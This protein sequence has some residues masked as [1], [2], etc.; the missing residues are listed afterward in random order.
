MHFSCYTTDEQKRTVEEAFRAAATKYTKYSFTSYGLLLGLNDF[1]IKRL[2]G[3]MGQIFEF[4]VQTLKNCGALGSGYCPVCGKGFEEG[5]NRKYAI[6]GAQ[7]TV[8]TACIGDINRLIEAENADFINAPNN[9]L[10]GFA[11]ALIGAVVG[12]ALC[13]LIYM[14]GY[15][16]TISA[17]ISIAIG[18]FLYRKFGGK[19]NWVMVVMISVLTLIA[20]IAALYGA[21]IIQVGNAYI[22]AGYREV[23]Y[24]EAFSYEMTYNDELREAFYSDLTWLIVFTVLGAAFMIFTIIKSIKRPTTIK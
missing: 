3:R 12:A 10:K 20:M 8:H 11:G 9:Y 23:N 24:I 2:A 19:Q 1:T 14:G 21:A 6:D 15:L 7:I 17:F 13:I 4:A 18:W 16:S 5:E 22:D